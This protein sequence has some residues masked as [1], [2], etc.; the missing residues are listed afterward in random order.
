M[1]TD[2]KPCCK[3][4]TAGLFFGIVL[5]IWGTTLIIDTYLQIDLSRNLFPLFAI[6]LGSY[7]VVT[8]FRR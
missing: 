6:V 5:L 2:E 8:G 7:L 3:R 1:A 4:S